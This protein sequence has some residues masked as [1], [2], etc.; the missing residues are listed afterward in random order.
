[1]D[2][3]LVHS[4]AELTPKQWDNLPKGTSPFWHYSF[5]QAL[6]SS[7]SIGADSGWHMK[8]LMLQEQG[9]II[10]LLPLWQKSHGMGEYIFD[11]MFAESWQHFKN[12]PYYPKLVAAVPF[13]PVC[14]PKLF[15][16]ETEQKRALLSHAKFFCRQESL[17][18]LHLNFVP[19]DEALLAE[20]EGFARRQNLQCHWHDRGYSD[21][22]DFLQTLPRSRRK[23]IRKE[24][25][26][27]RQQGFRFRRLSGDSLRG[28]EADS[29]WDTFYRLYC[30]TY[31]RKWGYPYFTRD[32]FEQGIRKN[33]ADNTLL[34]VG[35][36]EGSVR[37]VALSFFD[38]QALYGR[39]W[40]AASY[41]PCL[42]FETCYYQSIVFALERGL[43]RVEAGTQGVSHKL[44]RG[45]EPVLLSSVHFFSE[46]AFARAAAQWC[47]QESLAMEEHV[48]LLRS[49]ATKKE[50][51]SVS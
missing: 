48:A 39:H 20:E 40:G 50:A 33:L 13:T 43:S 29:L 51:L 35:E 36:Q 4:I 23:T 15:A 28:K 37:S 16:H 42:H 19:N 12:A 26:S 21:F 22:D 47:A 18:S 1:M 27:L 2:A 8:F 41:V 45:F 5:V 30:E 46:L 44:P 25:A 49:Q 32:F 17:S 14:L 7:R 10:A 38:E 31:A 34:V 9:N 11:P 6:E 24:R 3:S